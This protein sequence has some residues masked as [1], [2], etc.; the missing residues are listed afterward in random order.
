MDDQELLE[1]ISERKTISK[2][3]EEYEGRKSTSL[4]TANRLADFLGA[5]MI[6]D[7]GLNCNLIISKLPA[8]APVTERAIPVAIF[9][10]EPAI[11]RHFLRKW[12][13]DPNLDC[14]DFRD[15]V[16]WQYYKERL[17]KTIQKIITIPAGMQQVINPCPRVEHPIWLQRGFNEK[18]SGK[19]QMS[20]MQSIQNM[21]LLRN[22][23]PSVRTIGDIEDT[24]SSSSLLLTS[25]VPPMAHFRKN[26]HS[27]GDI[28]LG[29]EETKSNR[30]DSNTNQINDVVD[31]VVNGVVTDVVTDPVTISPGEVAIIYPLS[32]HSPESA[33]EL[34]DWLKDRKN[35][36]LA[37]RNRK[38]QERS[39]TNVGNN[40]SYFNSSKKSMGVMDF[41][42][43]ASLAVSRGLWQVIEVQE[44][45]A[46]GEFIIWAMTSQ[47]Q[48][49]KLRI[50]IDRT[51]YVDI[52]GKD[53]EEAA[54]SLGGLKV[55][56]DLPRNQV[57]HNL[58]EVSIPERK[59]ARN[60]K[61]LN[62]FLFNS[63][64][65]GVY[66][67]QVPLLFR[68]LVRM[69]CVAK[70]NSNNNNNNNP[71]RKLKLQEIELIHTSAHPYLD[72]SVASFKRIFVYC[73]V[74]KSR[75]NGLGILSMFI[76]DSSNKE[77]VEKMQHVI[78]ALDKTESIDN[79]LN[80]FPLPGKVFV[81]LINGYGVSAL[82]TRPPYNRLYRKYQPDESVN[83]K[84]VSQYTSSVDDA[85][86]SC[87]DK[88]SAYQREQHGPTI[89]VVQGALESKNWR[90]NLK[91]LQDF[92]VIMMPLN[93]L[94]EMFP[95]VGWQMFAT[96]RMIQRMLLFPNWFTD[97]LNSARYSH[98]P[99]CNLGSDVLTTV[100]DVM[101]ARQLIHNRHLLWASEESNTPD[102]GGSEKDD[103][104]IWSESL[105]EPTI[106]ES[107]VYRSIC[108]EL[109]IFGLAV[110]SIVSS[111]E[112]DAE[113]ITTAF[114]VNATNNADNKSEFK[115]G[116]LS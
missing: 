20:I 52:I 106:N 63:E 92:P 34:S 4:T 86:R 71:N 32:D 72:P 38:K 93:N 27:I 29:E 47:T 26:K 37:I 88:L 65:R 6:K 56:K 74:D 80:T 17:G 28:Y 87:N 46:L 94:D 66:E 114:A 105:V 39:T 13:K 116:T 54:K 69:G 50:T 62:L 110:C 95:A 45:D 113:G 67:S 55:S 12:L 90:N 42:R 19:K 61:S 5:E 53:M 15:V 68:A 111:S 107:G 81:W 91:S 14:D 103:S 100:I 112:L 96:T 60:E 78:N 109:D 22:P 57:G 48:L 30:T 98:I 75:N 89:V 24:S 77:E 108:V 83:V 23:T 3:V 2:T 64:V 41:V 76:I 11:K 58:Y 99:I 9:S 36:W 101:F 7:K 43:N 84:F 18:A 1:L 8:G 16:D 102:L 31:D 85:F 70:V 115:S 33:E 21:N 104:A 44:T 82:D 59:F 97:R 40:V 73:A 25:R 10:C 35:K 49:Q 79:T 51:V